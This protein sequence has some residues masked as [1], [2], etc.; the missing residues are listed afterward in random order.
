MTDECDRVLGD[1]LPSLDDVL[2]HTPAGDYFMDCED[3]ERHY[4]WLCKKK[5]VDWRDENPELHAMADEK[6]RERAMKAY[7][8]AVFEIEHLFSESN[9]VTIYR[10]MY[11]DHVGIFID[12]L[13]EHGKTM[14]RGEMRGVGTYWSWELEGAFAYCGHDV[15]T[16]ITLVSTAG[17]DDLDLEMMIGD[18]MQ[19]SSGES[20]MHEREDEVNLLDGRPIV[21]EQILTRDGKN[22]IEGRTIPAWT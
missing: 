8:E 10:E 9:R 15:G 3:V 18:F 11:V 5:G 2:D 4:M 7:E 12:S 17:C 19:F 14:Y 20:V 16:P 21:I 13:S 1:N 22:L 6:A